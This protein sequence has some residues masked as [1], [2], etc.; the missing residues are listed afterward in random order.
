MPG[1]STQHLQICKVEFPEI[2]LKTRDAHKLR[3]YFGNLFKEHSPLLSNHYEDGTFRYRYPLVQYKVLNH[4]PVLI[5][6]KEG[7]ELLTQLFL[8]INTLNID[9]K[10]YPIQTKNISSSSCEIGFS[11][12]LHEYKFKTLWLALNQK[13]HKK[14]IAL[15]KETEK[16]DMLKSILIGHVLSLFRN[17]EVELE[18]SQR[19]M[20]KVNVSQKQTKFKDKKMI[21]FTGSFIINA[22]LPNDLGLGKSVARGFGSL[23]KVS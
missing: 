8:K 21:A 17:T 12:E 4:I 23:V 7:G 16:E 15:E 6:I 19:L 10:V 22:K 20:A 9:N 2:E 11:E 5:G 14:Y 1:L 3:G 13:N 18:K